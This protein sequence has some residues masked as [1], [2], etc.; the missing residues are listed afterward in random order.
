MKIAY[1]GYDAFYPCLSALV[2]GG[3]EITAV[4]SFPTDDS[5]EYNRRL[6]TFAAERGLPFSTAR[7]TQETLDRLAESGIECLFSAG[8]IY[9]L[10]VDARFLQVN[11][12][13]A[14]L[15]VGRGAW[16]MPVAIL[17]GMR[18]YGTCLHKIAAGFDT[19]DIL[20][21]DRFSLDPSDNLETL[22][23]KINASA[24][25]LVRTFSERPR[26]YF[27][28]ARPQDNGEYWEEPSDSARTLSACDSAE[29]LDRVSRAFYGY[30]ILFTDRE[31]RSHMLRRA[32]YRKN[33]TP[34]PENAA[35]IFPVTDGMLIEEE[36]V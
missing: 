30:G 21:S 36:Q 35:R 10:P 25:S 6:R 3:H 17:R 34:I 18:D 31:G 13:P 32:V 26:T 14:P 5:Y 29:T 28:A 11:F 4:F 16:P 7:I 1:I 15:P 9:R 24:V 12:H 22:Q 33:G 27:D 8:Y 20:L 19:G 2:E 23:E